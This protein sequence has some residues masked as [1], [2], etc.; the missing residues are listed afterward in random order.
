MLIGCLHGQMLQVEVP[1]ELQSYTT[2]SFL[3]EH[4]PK[5][6]NFVTY[7]AQIRRD[8]KLKEIEL[9]KSKKREIKRK[10]MNRILKENPGLEID[11]DIFLGVFVIFNLPKL[12]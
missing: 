8:I 5:V 10:E 6:K 12:I 3:L 7:K 11:E 4:E 2:V 1:D 9:K